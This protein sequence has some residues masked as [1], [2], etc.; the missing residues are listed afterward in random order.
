MQKSEKV[1]LWASLAMFLVPEILFFTSPALIMSLNGKS[2]SEINSLVIRYDIFFDY[3]VYLLIIIAI[4]FLGILSLLI[5]S[6]KK[7]KILFAVLLFSI[8]IWLFFIFALCHI[9]GITISF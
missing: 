1:W 2:F 7:R 3:P 6:I 5:F 9:T 8:L 4:E